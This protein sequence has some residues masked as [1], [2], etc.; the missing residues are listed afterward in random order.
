MYG[1]NAE[2]KWEVVLEKL[3]SQRKNSTASFKKGIEPN[4]G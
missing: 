1:V 3:P 2:E 4:S